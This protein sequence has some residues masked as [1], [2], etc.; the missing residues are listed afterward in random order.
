[1]GGVMRQIE[2]EG[3]VLEVANN[4]KQGRPV[5]DARVEI[6]SAWPEPK[7]AAR[8][9]AGHANAAH[10]EPI[11]WI[12]GIDDKTREIKGADKNDLASWYPQMK[13][14]FNDLAPLITDHNIPYEG[15][16]IVALLFETERAPFVVKNSVHG[17]Q[18]AG[19]VS[20]EVPWREG[21]SVRS[22][23]R[24]DLIRLLLPLERLPEVKILGLHLLAA[25]SARTTTGWRLA[26]K[27]YIAS[28]TKGELI[29][30]FHACSATADIGDQRMRVTFDTVH[31]MPYPRT[32]PGVTP[33][34]TVR[35]SPSELIVASAGMAIFY[36]DGTSSTTELGTNVGD[37]AHIRI[38]LVH[39]HDSRP[40]TLVQTIKSN[41][42]SA[43]TGQWG[44]WGTPV[45]EW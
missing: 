32:N 7:Q 26:A 21:T 11:L 30:P 40:V 17:N 45:S 13:A 28:R 25:M 43:N 38:D 19:P 35:H 9:I 15:K 22:A 24:S 33:S 14:E 10:G 44:T 27:I 4:I 16:T 42:T 5:E 31:L 41:P 12:I 3:W 1:M 39:A 8:R 18:G 23:T 29:I 36:G 20:F 37:P 2:I 34:L 6:K